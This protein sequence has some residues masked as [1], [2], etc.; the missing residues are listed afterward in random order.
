M[1]TSDDCMKL[2][3]LCVVLDDCRECALHYKS[4]DPY[5]SCAHVQST[6]S[7]L[8]KAFVSMSVSLRMP[9]CRMYSKYCICAPHD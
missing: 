8:I 1:A 9:S 7:S 2:R 5:Q 3:L 6:Y 4:T